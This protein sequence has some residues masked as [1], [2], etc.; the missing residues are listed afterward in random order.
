MDNT[1]I[2]TLASSPLLK[3]LTLDE[4]KVLNDYFSYIQLQINEMLFNEGDDSDFIGFVV[5][6]EL[7]ILKK[8]M[9]GQPTVI[10]KIAKGRAIGEMALLDRLPRSASVCANS[11]ATICVL[12]RDAF[13]EMMES[14]PLIAAKIYKHIARTL[15]LNLRKTSNTLTDLI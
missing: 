11:G 3:E 4:L 14:H 10:G 8:T 13:T 5:H 1:T 6:G 9:A 15:S 7:D 2:D 12:T